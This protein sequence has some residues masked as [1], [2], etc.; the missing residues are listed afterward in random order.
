MDDQ[1][2]V[3]SNDGMACHVYYSSGRLPYAVRLI[4]TDSDNTVTLRRFIDAEHAH[5]FV[6]AC[7]PN[8]FGDDPDYPDGV[9]DSNY[10]VTGCE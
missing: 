4:D 2:F 6:R 1:L 10:V 5:A 8:L 9:D 3:D 7:L